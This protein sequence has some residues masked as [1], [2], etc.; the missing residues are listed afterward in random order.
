MGDNKNM[1]VLLVDDEEAFARALSERLGSRGVTAETVF[2]G[3]EALESIDK[4]TPDV[5]ILDLKM[6]GVD[7]M[8]VLRRVKKR[9]PGIQTIILSGYTTDS[10]VREAAQLGAVDFLGK[11]TDINS[12]MDKIR[13]AFAAKKKQGSPYAYGDFVLVLKK[14]L[15]NEGIS[16]GENG[17]GIKCFCRD[18]NQD[19]LGFLLMSAGRSTGWF[20]LN[21]FGAYPAGRSI[22]SFGPPS[23]HIPE[24]RNNPWTVVFHATHVGCDSQYTLGM[25]DRYGMR[26]PSSSCGLVA[27]VLK[28]HNDRRRGKEPAPFKDFEMRETEQAL[29]PFLD[30]ILTTPHPMAAAA[31]KLFELGAKIFDTLLRENGARSFYIG[32][33]NVDYD[34]DNPENNL[35]VPKTICIYEDAE[36]RELEL[37]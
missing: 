22:E 18:D 20:D 5:M 29:L 16:L 35:F 12:L 4:D 33:I 14:H 25:T 3:K 21:A 19:Q 31:E 28:R 24:L 13:T 30:E 9:Y 26:Q 27:A 17:L 2:G 36:K 15:A 37:H 32:G 10:A 7:G 8:E 34:A 6:P 23:H 1:K 11:P